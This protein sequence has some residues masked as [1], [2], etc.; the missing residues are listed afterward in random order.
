MDYAFF[1]GCIAKNVYPGIE[2]ATRIVFEKMNVGL[3]DY[4]YSCCP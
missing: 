4:P 3:H 2:K 1:P